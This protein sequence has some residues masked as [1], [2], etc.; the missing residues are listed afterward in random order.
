[1]G[2]Q[3]STTKVKRTFCRKSKRFPRSP[4]MKKELELGDVIVGF[5]TSGSM[6]DV[7]LGKGID[8]LRKLKRKCRRVTLIQ[9]DTEVKDVT[10]IPTGIEKLKIKGRGGTELTPIVDKARE[11]GYPRIPLI[12]YTDG[13]VYKF[14]EKLKN[15]VWLFTQRNTALEFKKIRPEI[16]YAL[17]L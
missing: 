16:S 17:V 8:I 11:M 14:P 1:M 15:S 12:M 9:G 6:S 7:E 4:G 13:E 3:P 2:C 10:R 5:D